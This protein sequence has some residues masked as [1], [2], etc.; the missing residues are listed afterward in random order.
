MENDNNQTNDWK[1]REIGALWRRSG[2]SQKYLSGY[3]KMGD[4]LDPQEVRLVVF[5]NKYKND[6]EKA[7][8]F[9]V[10]KSEPAQKQQTQKTSATKNDQEDDL[11]Q[12]LEELLK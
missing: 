6:N 12:E 10:Y 5:S 11:E 2:K 1:E 7:P 3:V 8:D 9:V 4:E